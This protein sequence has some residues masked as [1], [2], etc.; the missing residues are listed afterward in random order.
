MEVEKWRCDVMVY[1]IAEMV[2]G[3][4]MGIANHKCSTVLRAVA[5]K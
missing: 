3:M 5:K 2:W 4:E 1:S